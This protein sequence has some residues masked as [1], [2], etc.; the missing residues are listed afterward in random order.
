MPPKKVEAPPPPKED[1]NPYGVFVNF[2]IPSATVQVRC[3]LTKAWFTI[4]VI[5]FAWF[6]LLEGVQ[7][8]IG[9]LACTQG[10]EH[11]D[12]L[13]KLH[14]TI[15]YP[16]DFAPLNGE[17]AEPAEGGFYALNFS[18]RFRCACSVC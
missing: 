14:I 2:A 1:T 9:R 15:T 18:K 12:G 3:P 16:G 5:S 7:C 10:L 13:N 11:P 4:F 17:H 8:N 6:L